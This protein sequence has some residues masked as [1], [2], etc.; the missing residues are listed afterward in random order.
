MFFSSKIGEGNGMQYFQGWRM[1]ESNTLGNESQHQV[2]CA[3]SNSLAPLKQY[4]V[5]FFAFRSTFCQTLC[6]V[7]NMKW[8]HS[9]RQAQPQCSIWL[10]LLLGEQNLS[11]SWQ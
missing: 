4:T 8:L 7:V 1:N 11:F 10:Y 3:K 9:S 5:N 2:H 6:L